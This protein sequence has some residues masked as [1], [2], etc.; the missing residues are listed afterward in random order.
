[1]FIG[2]DLGKINILTF[3]KP[4]I[5]FFDKTKVRNFDNIIDFVPEIRWQ[6]NRN[7]R[8]NFNSYFY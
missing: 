2:D 3:H 1:M 8:V 4:N 7:E 5:S 6:L